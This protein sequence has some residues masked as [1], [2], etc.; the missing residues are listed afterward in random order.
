MNSKQGEIF[1]SS[2]LGFEGYKSLLCIAKNIIVIYNNITEIKLIELRNM[3]LL[4]D[5]KNKTVMCNF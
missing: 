5:V 2:F 4:Y 3:H 1:V